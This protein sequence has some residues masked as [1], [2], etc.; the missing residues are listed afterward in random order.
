MNKVIIVILV[1][2]LV[3][4]VSTVYYYNT[5]K[6]YEWIEVPISECSAQD[7]NTIGTQGKKFSC[8]D[9][10][11]N[12]VNNL[13]CFLLQKPE[14]NSR[15]FKKDCG[16]NCILFPFNDIKC[17]DKT[18]I[19]TQCLDSNGVAHKKFFDIKC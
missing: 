8:A 6:K 3:V 18:V 13:L 19:G 11:G 17:D 2:V 10:D 9:K 1:I 5:S 4:G 14:H 7:C 12:L 16:N 15:C